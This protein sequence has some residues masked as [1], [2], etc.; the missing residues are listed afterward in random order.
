MKKLIKLIKTL[1]NENVRHFVYKIK[2]HWIIYSVMALTGLYLYGMVVASFRGALY[3]FMT[4][5]DGKMFTLNPIKCIGAVFTPQGLG[6]AFFIL[7]MYL[8]IKQNWLQY[9][10]GVKIKKDE[11]NFY[12]VNEGTHGTS[13][14]MDRKDMKKTFLIGTADSVEGAILGK[15]A[16]RGFYEYLGL[17]AD[18][19]LNKHIM[20]YGASGSGKSRGFI[21]PFILKTAKLMQSMIIVD[22]KAEMA[23]QMAEYL[24]EEGYVV[25]MFNL[26]DMENSDA[27]N[28][29]GE[30]DG[31]IDMVQSVAVIIRNTSE[32]GQKADFWDK[33]EKNLLVALIHYV[34]TSKDPVTGELLP[35]QKRSLDTIYNMLSHDGQKE[36]DAKMQ[37]LPLD[38]PARA[39]YGIFKQAAGNL[40]GNI[41]IGLGS[42]LNV[43]QNKL[44]KK[45]TS[46]HEI[47]LELPGK[48][49]C[50][51]FCIIS[52]QDSSL[53]FLSSLFFSLLFKKLSDYARKHGDERGR[54][55]VEVNMVLEEFCNIGRLL[56][57]KK[58]ISTVRSRGI[59]CQIAAQSAAQMADRY[60]V[61]EWQE[62]VGNCDTQIMLGCN[63]QMTSEFISKKCG[64]ITIRTTSSM[65]PQTPLFSPITR[66]VN[67]Y[68]QNTSNATRPLMY[69]DEIE[70]MDNRECLILVRGQK[71]LKAMKIIPDEL[72]EFHKLKRTRITEYV[73][74]WRYDE[75]HSM[76]DTD[77]ISY[78][79]EFTDIDDV[80]ESPF[81]LAKVEIITA[82]AKPN[83][84]RQ[85]NAFD[86]SV[87]EEDFDPRPLTAQ[88]M[89]DKFKR[90]K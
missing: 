18:N 39:P 24:K 64:N 78:E 44:V 63:D 75:E 45:I 60:P 17:N 58:T 27:W 89:I 70:H 56:D 37:R 74:K 79:D 14:W 84:K 19:G 41:F 48:R 8:L 40:W 33:A 42:R 34:Y 6:I 26:L 76:S 52:D 16:R 80:E 12:T 88:S 35:I 65:A 86:D 73:P 62:I 36:L 53:E 22:P 13:G 51:Y 29:L 81:D 9:I 32:E 31:D 4:N 72:S 20:I 10:T 50:A 3:N 1:Y 54:L 69:P 59:N 77:N 61:N 83:T 85:I 46:Y 47:D 38:H 28:C 7:I 23:E 2:E 30:I 25:K 68:K 71:P 11:R 5:T 49:P 66:Q 43:F 82:S 87:E 15:L 90:G 21:K 57:F 67:G 55:P